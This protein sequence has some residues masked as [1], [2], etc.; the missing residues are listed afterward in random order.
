MSGIARLARPFRSPLKIGPSIEKTLAAESVARPAT[1]N[2]GRS[3]QSGNRVGVP[4]RSPCGPGQFR[5]S[6]KAPAP[7][8]PR[9]K[10]RGMR[11]TLLSEALI[12]EAERARLSSAGDITKTTWGCVLQGFTTQSKPDRVASARECLE[13]AAQREPS[14]PN[15]WESL[16]EVINVQRVWGWGLPQEEASVDK[17]AHDI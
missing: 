16:A 7:R 10:S 2:G 17:R 15:V 3:S 5:R 14:N 11:K 4:A 8:P 12:L 13:A 9:V 1:Q 6:S